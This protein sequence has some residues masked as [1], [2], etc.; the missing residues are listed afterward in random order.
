MF[1]LVVIMDN[2]GMLLLNRMALDFDE[3]AK[4]W[5]SLAASLP[6]DFSYGT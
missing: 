6:S 2:Y 5:S 3:Y 1:N 4:Q